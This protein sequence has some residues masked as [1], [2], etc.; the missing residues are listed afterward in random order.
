[1]PVLRAH[2]RVLVLQKGEYDRQFVYACE[3]E[4]DTL[5]EEEGCLSTLASPKKRP[6]RCD[7]KRVEHDPVP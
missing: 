6:A 4:V 2:A 5:G 3:H 1:M 7:S